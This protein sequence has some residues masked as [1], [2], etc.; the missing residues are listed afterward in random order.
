MSQKEWELR[1]QWKEELVQMYQDEGIYWQKRSGGQWI[2]DGTQI[3][4]ITMV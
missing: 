3:P 4:H 1:Y 2:L